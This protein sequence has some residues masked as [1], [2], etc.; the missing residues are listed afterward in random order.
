MFY[1]LAKVGRIVSKIHGEI[2]KFNWLFIMS[3]YMINNS[4]Y[5]WKA[6]CQGEITPELY[7]FLF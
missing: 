5:F 3:F 2:G 1:K 7:I 6:I 4:F